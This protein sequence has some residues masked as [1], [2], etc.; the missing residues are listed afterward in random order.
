MDRALFGA[1]E[2]RA[3]V[4]A[5]GAQRQCRHQTAAVAEAARGDDRN[6]Y[7]IGGYRDQDQARRIVL[8]GMARALKTVDRDRIDAPALRR[9][10]VTDAGGFLTAHHAVVLEF[11]V[12]F[13]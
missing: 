10:G 8:A 5:F 11:W 4:D 12:L 3:H 2:T 1:H 6:F 9:P 13:L 7:F